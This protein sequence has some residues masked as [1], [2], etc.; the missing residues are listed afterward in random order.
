[1]KR[2]EGTRLNR[3]ASPRLRT[4]LA[5][6]RR[7]GSISAVSIMLAYKVELEAFSAWRAFMGQVLV[8]VGWPLPTTAELGSRAPRAW[9]DIEIARLSPK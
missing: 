7:T 1:M 3:E 2:P 8:K 6:E 4:A 5:D 9:M